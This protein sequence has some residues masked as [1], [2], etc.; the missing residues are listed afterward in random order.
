MSTRM[1]IV[2]M[3]G[4]AHPHMCAKTSLRLPNSMLDK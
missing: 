2:H 1:G 4:S 3:D